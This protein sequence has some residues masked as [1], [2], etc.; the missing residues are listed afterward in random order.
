MI[1]QALANP[2]KYGVS[3]SE[4]NH[5]TEQGTKNADVTGN[6][7]M[8][9]EDAGAIQRYLLKLIPSLPETK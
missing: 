9:T 8:T 5:I 7:G 2:N 3:G 4:K 6:N 1:M